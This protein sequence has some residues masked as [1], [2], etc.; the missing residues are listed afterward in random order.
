MPEQIDQQSGTIGVDV[1]AQRVAEDIDVMV[2]LD[3]PKGCHIEAHEP[4]DDLLIP[5]VVT[6]DNL[7]TSEVRYPEPRMKDLGVGLPPLRV[8]RDEVLIRA[9]GKA[10]SSIRSLTG[11][12]RY[13]PCAGNACLPPREQ[14][15][16][17]PIE[18]GNATKNPHPSAV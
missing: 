15:W 10:C 2:R 6:F 17:A 8:Y 9:T 13:Q 14:T 7:E 12:I 16:T 18:G 11:T 5:T 1:S 4:A 3:I